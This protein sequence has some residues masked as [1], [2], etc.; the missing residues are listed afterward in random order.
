MKESLYAAADIGATGIKMAAAVY[1]GRKLRI[2][3]TYSE[4]NLPKVKN[5]HEFAHIGH[6]LKTIRDGL[7]LL[8]QELE[9]DS[10]PL[11]ELMERL[12]PRS[13]GPAR[14]LFQGC[15]ESLDCLSREPFSQ[16]WRRLTETLPGLDGETRRTLEP[17]G[18]VLGR[19]DWNEQRRRVDTICRRVDELR[20]RAEERQRRQGKVYRA[21][22]AAGGA[23]LVILL[24]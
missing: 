4:P 7:A 24:L 21:L 6:M 23:F 19:C 10:P 22:G 16:G 11:P 15:R 12:I 18:D 5:G 13:A 1:D 14:A 8:E 9:L 20:V 3:D 2:A 17:L